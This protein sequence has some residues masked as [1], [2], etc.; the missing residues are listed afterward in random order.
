MRD[1][2][3][4]VQQRP[5]PAM[6]VALIATFLLVT[7]STSANA[8]TQDFTG[9]VVTAHGDTFASTGAPAFEYFLDTGKERLKL[10]FAQKPN[11]AIGSVITV[12][13]QRSGD[14]VAVA[15]ESTGTSTPTPPVDGEPEAALGNRNVLV[16]LFN[17]SNDKSQPYL[18]AFAR[19]VLTGDANSVRN[20]FIEESY[21][22]L[23]VTGTVVGWYQIESDNKYCRFINWANLARSAAVAHGV[24]ISL[25]TNIVYAF[26]YNSGCAWSGLGY[27][28]GTESFNNGAMRTSI[29]AHELSHNFGVHHAS[30]LNCT[31]NGARV[32]LSTSCTTSEYGDPFDVMGMGMTRHTNNWNRYQLDWTSTN[33]ET[34]TISESG[35]YQIGVVQQASSAPKVVRL[36]R[37]DGT[38]LYLEV[39]RAFGQYFDNF[40]SSDPVV[41]GVTIRLAPDRAI[42]QSKLIDTTPST[43]SFADA[44]LALGATF[45]DPVSKSSIKVVAMDA[46]GA[47]VVIRTGLS[48]VS[49]PTAPTRPSGRAAKSTGI[50]SLKWRGSMDNVGVAAYVI[51]RSGIARGRTTELVYS[52]QLPARGTYSFSIVAEDAAGNASAPANLSIRW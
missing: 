23:S 14:S 13:G 30:S 52:D 33:S 2:K 25:Y 45:V 32:A 38:F 11:V 12:R 47:T 9:R 1:L 6:A 39:R 17:F 37:P 4:K 3:L 21:G 5:R 49:A 40:S 44:P 42:V 28:P 10:Q 51:Y 7:A 15:A 50:V 26:P 36:R 35:T 29:V 34:Q 48:D 27:M 31:E 18:P 24:D 20:Y 19:G 8:P 43:T 46:S 41:Q 22:Q 16:I